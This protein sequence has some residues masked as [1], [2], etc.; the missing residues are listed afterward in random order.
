MF[1][2]PFDNIA[3]NPRKA[4]KNWGYNAK[5]NSTRCQIELYTAFEDGTVEKKPEAVLYHHSDGYPDFMKPK[6]E[7]F[8]KATYEL[9]KK[10]G[11]GY[12]WDGERVAAVMIML[13][14]EDYSQPLIPYSTNRPDHYASG[15]SMDAVYR[16][17]GGIPVFQPACQRHGD[18]EYLYKVIIGPKDGDYKITYKQV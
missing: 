16:P 7:R 14:A 8:L 6:L 3:D 10:A 1:Q 12:W 13:S 15:A 5:E 4:K 2:S 9:M 17:N 18:I 11:H